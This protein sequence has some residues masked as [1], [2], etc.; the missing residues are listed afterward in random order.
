MEQED[1]IPYD[2]YDLIW[3]KPAGVLIELDKAN[4]DKKASFSLALLLEGDTKHIYKCFHQPFK[5]IMTEGSSSVC[6]FKQSDFKGGE[7]YKFFPLPMFEEFLRERKNLKV[8]I[9][10]YPTSYSKTP[11]CVKDLSFNINTLKTGVLKLRWTRLF[12]NKDNCPYG[13]SS[14]QRVRKFAT[15]YE[16]LNRIPS[17]F[18]ITGIDSKGLRYSNG[19]N[20]IV[21]SCNNSLATKRS[22][23]YTIGLLSDID[24][25]E[26][27]R[28][29]NNY[30]KIFVVVPTDY[31]IF[32]NMYMF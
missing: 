9:K 11:G 4:M 2:N 17:M 3:R 28:A 8:T 6:R 16:V 25:L 14:F 31:F 5:E 23:R 22:N 20:Y 21:R 1:D 24:R 29:N 30:H 13:A 10:L 18:P 32:H 7:F 26:Q 27:I 19:Q 12:S 15:S